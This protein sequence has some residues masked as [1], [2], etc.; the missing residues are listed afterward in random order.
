MGKETS[1]SLAVDGMIK[2]KRTLSKNRVIEIRSIE[3]QKFRGSDYIGGVHP[4]KI[5]DEGIVIFPHIIERLPE[6]REVKEILKTGISQFDELLE[7]GLEF[8]TA[9]L[10]SGPSGIGKTSLGVNLL[11]Q[12]TNFG[13]K[14]VIYTFE[15]AP[16]S[17]I[18]RAKGISISNRCCYA[19]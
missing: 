11:I 3:V 12:T 15:E 17:I 5:K 7:G 19:R 10:I 2:L 18:K 4:L 6:K 16:A 14:E 1:V 8:G 13:K 9:T